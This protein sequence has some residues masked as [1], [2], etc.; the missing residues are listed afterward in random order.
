MYKLFVLFAIA[1]TVLMLVNGLL[2]LRNGEETSARSSLWGS[3]SM[4]FTLALVSLFCGTHSCGQGIVPIG[5]KGEAVMIM[6]EQCAINATAN[7]SGW[8][9]QKYAAL[10]ARRHRELV[11]DHPD[12]WTPT[13]T[14]P[15][16]TYIEGSVCVIAAG[17]NVRP[18][19][20]TLMGTQC[21]AD[22]TRAFPVL[23]DEV[24]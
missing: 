13:H 16:Y 6:G 8:E 11:N 12:N 14:E 9:I 10:C 15:E 23:R 1:M 22:H 20:I 7:I 3:A 24:R 19:E 4:L 18:E 2:A 21:A 5:N 17:I